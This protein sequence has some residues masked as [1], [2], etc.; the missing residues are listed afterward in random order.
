MG[1]DELLCSLGIRTRG[2]YRKWAIKNHPDKGGDTEVFAKVTAAIG[3]RDRVECEDETRTGAETGPHG[4]DPP[5]MPE[6][7]KQ[8]KRAR[9]VRS[10]EN[11]SKIER[12]QRFDKPGFNKARMVK[13]MATYSPKMVALIEKIRALDRQDSARGG[14]L[15]KHFIYSDVNFGGHGAKIIASALLAHGFTPA[16]DNKG[17][18]TTPKKH[19][20]K[21][22]FALLSSTSTFDRTFNQKT[23]KSIVNMYN[24]RPS[25]VHGDEVRFI[26]L[27]SGFK[28]GID[29]FDVKYA[30][31]FETP[32]TKA[33][34]AQAVGR[35][36]R[37]CGQ[38]GLRFVP[39]VGW[40]LHVFTYFAK[41][42]DGTPLFER[43][44]EYDG[45]DFNKQ[46]FASAL[47]RTAMYAAVDHD[48]N[49]S[50]HTLGSEQLRIEAALKEGGANKM[51]G[52]D[53]S[54]KC[55]K[56][57]TTDVPFTIALMKRLLPRPIPNFDKMSAKE[58]RRALCET[59][60]KD[61]EYCK[62][63]N[64]AFVKELSDDKKQIELVKED[65]SE[66]RTRLKEDA[67][68][69]ATPSKAVVLASKDG[70]TPSKAVVASKARGEVV[71]SR[72][73]A[74]AK[75]APKRKK[76]PK[77]MTFE[78]H[79]AY[80]NRTFAKYKYPPVK[81]QDACKERPTDTRLVKYTE[82]QEFITRYFVPGNFMKGILVWHS[83]G[84]GKT[85]TALSVKSFLFDKQDYTVVWVT[86]N[87]LREDLWKNMFE[88]V[89]DHGVREMIRDGVERTEVLR[90]RIGMRTKF[91]P[92]MSYKQFSNMLKGKNALSER[93]RA[94]G[95]K[96]PLEKTLVIVDEAHKLYG[97]EL[98]ASERPDM[99]AVEKAIHES[100]T[101]KVVLMTGTPFTK[102]PMDFVRLLNLTSDD[103]LPEEYG[104]FH[105]E[106]LRE[107]EFTEAG[108][109]A[110]RERVKGR[111]SYL[112]R[113][114]DPRMFARPVFERVGVTIS[115]PDK[116][117]VERCEEEAKTR[118]TAC[119]EESNSK[120]IAARKEVADPKAGATKAER[121]RV[122]RKRVRIEKDLEK[123]LRQCERTEERKIKACQK[124]FKTESE[125]YQS[126]KLASC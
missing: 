103:A 27:D 31:L 117:S 68:S 59:L 53:A 101:A 92:P 124:A 74:S 22:T 9:C 85:C 106:F 112:N 97:D 6:L 26:V 119:T 98:P 18:L 2:D 116:A 20:S 32:R 65:L 118:R 61:A 125:A 48:L 39:N 50:I 105:R 82:S 46:H 76:S 70:A 69:K 23:V 86:R 54:V 10:V 122:E 8:P 42:T 109:R 100:P 43:F 29:L 73:K 64:E 77:D 78:E 91:L 93:L 110:F 89:C 123:S 38:T 88:R 58:K 1:K 90:K 94:D 13:E 52:C 113:T 3:K 16:F 44:T 99:E 79:R 66:M 121:L 71:S 95:R 120:A 33:D 21:E 56:R 37:S 55:G 35:G 115:A 83:V 81:I 25:N 17:R 104:A 72:P 102:D 126:S 7:K 12:H 5:P 34:E 47:E 15:H 51:R 24:K 11:W 45:V 111:I 80:V 114:F 62:R 63:V 75:T 87:T 84:T 60:R 30:H 49:E 107:N 41:D 28:E 19:A 96:H 67:R 36:T 57:S 14:Q 108:E 40:T 4:T